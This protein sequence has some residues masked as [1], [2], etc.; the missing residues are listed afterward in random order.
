MVYHIRLASWGILFVLK[1]GAIVLTHK[2]STGNGYCLA[3]T[4]KGHRD[5]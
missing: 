4:Y 1:Q 3:L 2:V 5:W